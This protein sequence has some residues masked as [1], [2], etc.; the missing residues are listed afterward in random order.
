MNSCR[1][2]PGRGRPP[3]ADPRD[4]DW[5]RWRAEK[6]GDFAERFY[7]ELK[8]KR[9]HLIVSVSPAIYPWAR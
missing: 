4:P 2:K 3:P 6:V 7:T 1:Q 8:E 9:P 5:V